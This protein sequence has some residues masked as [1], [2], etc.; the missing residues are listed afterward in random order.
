MSLNKKAID[1]VLLADQCQTRWVRKKYN[2]I[3]IFINIHFPPFYHNM[4]RTL[5]YII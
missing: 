5:R 1:W 4:Q 2:Q 3:L